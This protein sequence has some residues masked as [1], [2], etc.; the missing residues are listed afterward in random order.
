MSFVYSIVC[1]IKKQLCFLFH[2]C[3]IIFVARRGIT[4]AGRR[5]SQWGCLTTESLSR[6]GELRRQAA[7]IPKGGA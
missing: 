4:A 7:V 2:N 6:Q 1:Q 5:D 3:L